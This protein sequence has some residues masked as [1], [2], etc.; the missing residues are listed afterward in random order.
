MYAP[1][2]LFLA[3]I[4]FFGCSSAV[5]NGVADLAGGQQQQQPDFSATVSNDAGSNPS[6]DLSSPMG[7]VRFVAIGD[8]GKGNAGQKSVADAIAAKCQASGCDFVQLLG[9]NI[10]DSGVGSTT[11]GLWQTHFVMP[12]ANINV[13]F[14]AVLGNHDYGQD[15]A[16]ID[17]PRGQHEVDYTNVSTKWKMP[18][19]I[20]RHT[21][22]HVEF[23]GTDTNTQ[24]LKSIGA[25]GASQH[26]SDLK[27]WI[28]SSTATWKIAFGHHPYYSN[29]PHGNAGSYERNPLIPPPFNGRDVKSFLEGTI[30]GKVDLY[31][32][33]HDHVIDWPMTT[34]NGT[35]LIVSGTGAASTELEGSNPSHFKSLELGFLYVVIDGKTFTGEFFDT[36]G[37]SLFKRTITKP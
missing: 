20:W 7:T 24:F 15:G 30:C 34:C 13:P 32:C 26:E 16:G 5:P 4:L 9:D 19:K 14:W 27:S 37:A 29:G 8:V 35:E 23:F 3:G 11:D 18:G 33:G 2:G 6:A 22:R 1:R 25:P 31:I 21:E 10:Y 28:A 17:F 36:K 12:Y